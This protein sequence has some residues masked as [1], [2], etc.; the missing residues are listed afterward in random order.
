MLGPGPIFDLSGERALY[1]LL[2][3]RPATRCPDIAMLSAP[4]LG[5]E[6]LRELNVHPPRLV[7]LDKGNVP[8]SLGGV[9]KRDRIPLIAAW[10][11]A[12]YRVR[13]RAGGYLV[14]FQP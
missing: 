6:A 5:A 11:D 13:V 12:H 2:D 3:R 8:G 1:Y 14:G 7:I 4:E 10:I 9:A